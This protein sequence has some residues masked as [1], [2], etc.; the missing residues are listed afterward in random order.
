M[1][2]KKFYI[3]FLKN[4]KNTL[5]PNLIGKELNDGGKKNE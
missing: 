4:E 1:I 3:K 2:I 5:L